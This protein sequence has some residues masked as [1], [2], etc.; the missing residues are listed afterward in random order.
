MP[1]QVDTNI[2]FDDMLNSFML[3]LPKNKV[4]Q[5][6]KELKVFKEHAKYLYN[7]AKDEKINP[8]IL[9]SLAVQESNMGILGDSKNI[10]QVKPIAIKDLQK[11][12]PEKYKKDIKDFTARDYIDAGV[13]YLKT[14]TSMIA[15]AKAKKILGL[16]DLNA[17]VP[18][19]SE[20]FYRMKKDEFKKDLLNQM[21]SGNLEPEFKY[22]LFGSWNE[23]ITEVS[24]AYITAKDYNEFLNTLKTLQLSDKHAK[25]Y[26]DDVS[27]MLESS[28]IELGKLAN[29][30]KKQKL[31]TESE[32]IK[33]NKMLKK[34]VLS[35]TFLSHISNKLLLNT[36]KEK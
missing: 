7:K 6:E 28:R 1:T 8:L 23:G 4:P 20:D 15:G 30:Y 17:P 36:N 3:I 2:S 5:N 26:T 10:F 34:S 31:D 9:W 25:A 27:Y 29:E 11:N 24:N 22:L 14:L 12:Y 32:E 18:K 16:K 19:E 13:D 21:V 33:P 35:N